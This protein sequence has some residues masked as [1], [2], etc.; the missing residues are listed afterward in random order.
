M[1]PFY[2][3]PYGLMKYLKDELSRMRDL[4][5]DYA[6][7]T[8]GRI[9]GRIWSYMVVYTEEYGTKSLQVRDSIEYICPNHQSR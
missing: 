7:T 9:S 4:V 3:L 6:A 2:I 5:R 8:T 1:L